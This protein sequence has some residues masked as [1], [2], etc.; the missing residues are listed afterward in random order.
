[1]TLTTNDTHSPSAGDD[2]L[3]EGSATSTSWVH[4]IGLDRFSGLYLLGIFFI[5]FG[6]TESN[7]LIWNGSIEFV[8][9]EKVIV[10]MLALAFLVPL[11]TESC[12][13]D[14][15][16]STGPGPLVVWVEPEVVVEGAVAEWTADGRLRKHTCGISN[17]TQ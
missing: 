17:R 10:V 13:F 14:P 12:P 15:V 7:F 1:M 6:I 8:L 3:E 2:D 11:T 4:R 9:T 16:P 5:F